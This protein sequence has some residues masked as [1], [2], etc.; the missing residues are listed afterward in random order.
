VRQQTQGSPLATGAIAFGVR[1]LVAAAFPAS[2]A[3]Q[4]AAQGLMDNA[5]PLTDELTSLGKDVVEQVKGVVQEAVEEV[6]T[7][8][9]DGTQA[10][11]DTVKG[12]VES[13]KATTQDAGQS[14]KEQASS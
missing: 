7:T 6:K 1:F 12:G 3:E 9:A 4:H 11:A 14:I 8:A 2:Q 5:G 10:V 13:T